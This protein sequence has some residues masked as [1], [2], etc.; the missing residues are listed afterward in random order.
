MLA[1]QSHGSPQ[2]RSSQRVIMLIDVVVATIFPLVIRRLTISSSNSTSTSTSTST[3]PGER[4]AFG[5]SDDTTRLILLCL[6]GRIILF[7]IVI[8]G[9]APEP[10]EEGVDVNRHRRPAEHRRLPA[11]A[12][13]VLIVI[14]VIL[15]ILLVVAQ[16]P[17]CTAGGGLQIVLVKGPR[18]NAVCVP[19][20]VDRRQGWRERLSHHFEECVESA[21]GGGGERRTGSPFL[22][23]PLVWVIFLL[24]LLLLLLVVD[25]F[26]LELEL[27]LEIVFTTI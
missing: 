19:Y 11:G 20:V 27:V 10:T 14:L 2:L 3:S 4:D 7:D 9:D 21:E 5:G 16:D 23:S 17:G 24:L 18:C 22:I 6:N 12:F 26:V 8:I 15:F 13:I 25:E 1:M